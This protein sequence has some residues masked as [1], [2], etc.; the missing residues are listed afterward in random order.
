MRG[1]SRI[2]VPSGTHDAQN[3]DF[4]SN[5]T[6]QDRW[7]TYVC[8]RCK[9]RPFKWHSLKITGGRYIPC[10]LNGMCY[11]K[12]KLELKLI[13][14]PKMLENFKV[15]CIQIKRFRR[16]SHEFLN[17]TVLTRYVI[18]DRGVC[19][20]LLCDSNCVNFIWFFLHFDLFINICICLAAVLRIDSFG[21]N[22]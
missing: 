21:T 8:N 10:I 6:I 16:K 11:V 5:I 22:S 4:R 20:S 15:N 9:V 1:L 17:V 14:I 12:K 7:H 3:D 18:W 2:M 19:E 13:A